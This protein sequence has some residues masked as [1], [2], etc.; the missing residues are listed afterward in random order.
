LK[1]GTVVRVVAAEPFG[2]P[3]TI[4]IDGSTRALGRDIARFVTVEDVHPA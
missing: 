3:L 1:P 2:G 4:E